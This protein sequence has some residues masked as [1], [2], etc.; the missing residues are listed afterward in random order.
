MELLRKYDIRDEITSYALDAAA[1]VYELLN[2]LLVNDHNRI[3][4]VATLYTDTADFK[5]QE[6]RNLT[7][8]EIDLHPLMIKARQFLLSQTE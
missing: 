3:I 6:E 4:S 5:A 7:A 8:D 2:F 1:C